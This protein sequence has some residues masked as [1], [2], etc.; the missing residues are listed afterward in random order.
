MYQNRKGL[1][2]PKITFT[3]HISYWQKT[4]ESILKAYNGTAPDK[5]YFNWIP[6]RIRNSNWLLEVKEPSH[7]HDHDYERLKVITVERRA[8]VKNHADT[9]LLHNQIQTIDYAY[10]DSKWPKWYKEWL[11]KKRTNRAMCYY[12]LCKSQGDKFIQRKKK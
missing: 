5:W 6:E 12:E 10:H 8:V 1:L 3:A 2:S 7:I 4:A 11:R 9:H